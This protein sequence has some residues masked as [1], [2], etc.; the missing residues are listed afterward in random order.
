MGSGDF[1][2]VDAFLGGGAYESSKIDWD[3]FLTSIED[4]IT[5]DNLYTTNG[6]IPGLAVRT[7]GLS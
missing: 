4:Q 2:D 5:V 6:S 7:V 3:D 1:I